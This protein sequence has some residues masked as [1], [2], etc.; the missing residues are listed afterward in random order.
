MDGDVVTTPMCYHSCGKELTKGCYVMKM[1]IIADSS[2]DIF[3]L[4]GVDFVAAPLKIYTDEAE[5]IDDANLNVDGMLTYL[6]AYQGRSYTACPNVEVWE[7]A[8]AGAEEIYVVTLSSGVSGTWGAAAAA[9]KLYQEEHPEVKIHI[10]DTLSAGPEVRMLVE[11][12]AEDVKAGLP[13]EKVCSRGEDYMKKTRIFFALQSFHNFAENGRVSKAVAKIGGVLGIRIMATASEKGTIEVVDK[14][15]GDK[16]TQKKFVQK[17]REAGYQGGK[18]YMAHCQNIDFAQ[19]IAA[20]IKEE[21]SKEAE[22]KIYDTRGLCS[23]YA[24]R[25]GILLGFELG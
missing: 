12:I 21:F 2:C 15:R 23:Y 3:Q 19:A 25:G 20:A 4:E 22:I 1:R 14:C 18:I 16:G 17:L 10:F 9:A 6:A 11:K 8:Y 7:Q 24:E 13:F 5:F